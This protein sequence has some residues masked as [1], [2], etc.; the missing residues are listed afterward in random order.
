MYVLLHGLGALALTCRM[1]AGRLTLTARILTP[2]P[3]RDTEAS[4]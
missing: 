3:R 1:A 4:W 2:S